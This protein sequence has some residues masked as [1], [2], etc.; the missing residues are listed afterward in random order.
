MPEAG[1]RHGPYT[2]FYATGEVE[3][4]EYVK[5]KETGS[6]VFWTCA[7]LREDR[8]AWRMR[9]WRLTELAYACELDHGP[10]PLLKEVIE[11]RSAGIG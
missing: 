9:E 8:K 4:G 3:V 7:K 6:G 1:E 10:P 2:H 11:A 5:N